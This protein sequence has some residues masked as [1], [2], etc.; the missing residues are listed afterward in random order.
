MKKLLLITGILLS[1][2]LWADMDKLC[3]VDS[4]NMDAERYITE[5]CEPNDILE[6]LIDVRNISYWTSRW[7]RFDREIV[8]GEAFGEVGGM[9][10]VELVCVLYDVTRRKGI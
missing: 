6:A 9:R 8:I 5:M 3:Q 2:S 7:C 10:S 1:T 4:P